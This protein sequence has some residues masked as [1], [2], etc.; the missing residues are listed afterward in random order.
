[1][2]AVKKTEKIKT[3]FQEYHTNGFDTIKAYC[4]VYNKTE[5]NDAWERTKITKKFYSI[6]YDNEDILSEVEKANAKKYD[7]MKDKLVSK[8]EVAA[9]QYE[10]LVELA[11]KDKLSKEDKAKFARLKS[12]MSTKDYNKS[13]ELIGKLCGSFEATRTEVTNTYKVSFGE[14]NKLNESNPVDID[15]EEL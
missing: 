2:S 3:L 10:K 14:P 11:M 5:P 13:L 9:N 1:M 8:L 6:K 4:K 15:H 12:I 7:K